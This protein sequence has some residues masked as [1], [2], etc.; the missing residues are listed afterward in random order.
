MQTKQQCF[1]VSHTVKMLMHHCGSG[2]AK[3]KGQHECCHFRLVFCAR[4]IS[5]WSNRLVRI[6]ISMAVPFQQFKECNLIII[7][8]LLGTLIYVYISKY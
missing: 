7:R 2:L 6:D 8:R 1:M 5:S 4:V 3:E